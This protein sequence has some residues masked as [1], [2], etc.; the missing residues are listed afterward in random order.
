MNKLSD[1]FEFIADS[2][3]LAVLFITLLVI[4]SGG[5][6]SVNG[7]EGLV[8]DMNY[9]LG[10]LVFRAW[11][12]IIS[13]IVIFEIICLFGILLLGG[14][15]KVRINADNLGRLFVLIGETLYWIGL[16]CVLNYFKVLVFI[17]RSI[18]NLKKKIYKKG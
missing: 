11:V 4:F 8:W 12:M 6:F 17:K 9:L 1:L 16:I 7:H 10:D 14:S 2:A 18:L 5:T 13:L 3:V 15:L